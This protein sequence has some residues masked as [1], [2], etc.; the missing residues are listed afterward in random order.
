M[1]VGEVRSQVGWFAMAV[2]LVLCA[3]LGSSAF[4]RNRSR[5]VRK[6]DVTG[7][8]KKRIVSD[9]IEWKAGVEVQAPERIKAYRALNAHAQEVMAYLAAQGVKPAEIRAG[10]ASV[11]ELVET[12]LVGSGENR[13]ERK[14]H[15]GFEARQ[16]IT[17]RSGDV[18][19]VERLS[20]EITQL[21]ERGVPVASERPR[22]FYTRLGEL[23]VEMLAQAAKDARTRADSVVAQ[24]G[25]S[26]G[27]LR[28]ADMGVI[29][30]NPANSTETSWQGNNDTTSLEKDIVAIVHVAFE[31]D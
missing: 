7:S 4:E 21:L 24:T 23:K 2:A 14:V 27:R 18:E 29:N 6:I 5:A 15:K 28:S 3:L 19:R 26:L 13:F 1:S 9:L 22:Y 12:E 31:L 11:G 17:V 20:R 8:A 25:A 10:A 30:V 16:A